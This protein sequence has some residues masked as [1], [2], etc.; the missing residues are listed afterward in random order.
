MKPIT[1]KIPGYA[2]ASTFVAL[3]GILNGFDTGSVGA[4]TEMPFFTHTFGHLTPT[5][6]GFTVSLIMLCGAIPATVAGYLADR[7][8]RLRII[9]VGAILFTI[10]CVLECA[11]SHLSLFLVGRA[12]VGIGQGFALTNIGVYICEIA[13]SRNRGKFVSL[14]QFGA[15]LGVCVGYFSCYGSIHINGNMSWRLPYIL[16]AALSMVWAA[17]SFFLPESPRWLILHGQRLRAMQEL[18]KL[19]FEAVEAE[20]DVLRPTDNA[21]PEEQVGILQGLRLIFKREYRSQTWLAV[22][23]LSFVQLSGI[24]GVLYVCSPHPKARTCF[25]KLTPLRSTPRPSSLKPESPRKQP[26]SSRLVSPPSSCSPSAFPPHSSPTNG[27]VARPPSAAAS[28]SRGLCFQFGSLYAANVVHSDGAARWVVIVSVFVF[29]I[30]YV[31]TW[32][33]VGKIYASEIQPTK[34][35]ATTNSMATGGS[36]VSRVFTSSSTVHHGP[37]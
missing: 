37:D 5:M 16:Q 6:R 22:F 27:V 7:F 10:G 33:I 19:D 3:G 24:D 34:T 20:K 15:A 2:L 14:P 30:G 17:G 29:A 11:A 31:S 4:V 28:S 32:A 18:K 35:R 25:N 13:P 9:I 21:S 8:G 26:L 12:I 23:I 1:G 36:F